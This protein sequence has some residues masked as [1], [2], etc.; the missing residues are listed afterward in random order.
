MIAPWLKF[1]LVVA[2]I[3]LLVVATFAVGHRVVESSATF[4]P[5]SESAPV[6]V[7]GDLR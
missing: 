6:P 3:L 1:W 5:V 4:A 7:R 2:I